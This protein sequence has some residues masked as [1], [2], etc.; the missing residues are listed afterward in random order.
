MIFFDKSQV[1]EDIDSHHLTLSMENP[2]FLGGK[3]TKNRGPSSIV[4]GQI[5]RLIDSLPM[6]DP[7]VNG[8]KNANTN[9]SFC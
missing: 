4:V 5:N 7:Y 9:G 6:T 1:E 2:P 8:K 3:S